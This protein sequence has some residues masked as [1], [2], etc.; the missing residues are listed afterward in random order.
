MNTRSVLAVLLFSS[1]VTPRMLAAQSVPA[2]QTSAPPKAPTPCVDAPERHRF[3]FW[4]GEWDVTT[5]AG[6]SAGA[7]SVQSVSGGCALL[8]NWTSANGGHGKSLNA[9]NPAIGQWQQYWIGQDGNPTEFRESTWSGDSIVFRAHTAATSKSPAM[10]MR[11]TFTPVDSSTVRQHGE[12]SADGGATWTM[13]QA[14][15]AGG[16]ELGLGLVTGAADAAGNDYLTWAEAKGDDTAVYLSVSRDD[17]VTWGKPVVVDADAGSKVFPEVVAAGPGHVAVA[18]YHSS[19]HGDPAKVPG[20]ATWN[21]TLAWTHDA[22]DTATQFR[23]ATLSP[24]VLHEGPLC[25]DG[26]LC[27]SDRRL[28]DYFAL[29]TLPDGRVACVWTSTEDVSGKTVD[30]FGATTDAVL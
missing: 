16:A 28:L 17:G 2:T 3:D 9:F 18:Y 24:H 6:G 30:V 25:P 20:S 23:T 19:A 13:T 1:L 22:L 5:P 26:T 10:E 7:S 11:L 15:N 14:P 21:V 4:I 12:S 29:K 8:E 27:S